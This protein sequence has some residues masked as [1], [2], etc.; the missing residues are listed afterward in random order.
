MEFHRLER[1]AW[2]DP[3]VARAYSEGFPTVTGHVAGPLLEAVQARPGG[4]LADIACGPGTVGRRAVDLG[5]RVV[6]V[7]L[8]RAMLLLPRHPPGPLI[9]VQ[10]SATALPLAAGRFDA[11]VSNFGLLHF[12]DPEAALA[13]AAR[14]LRPGGR[15]GWSVWGEDAEA[16]RVIPKA[17]ES[18]G[19]RPELPA[20]PG[21]FQFGAP[22]RFSVALAGAGL[23]DVTVRRLAWDARFNDADAFWRAFEQGSARTR[24]AI[25]ALSEA[26]RTAVRTEV[27]RRLSE[28]QGPAGLAVPTTALVAAGLRP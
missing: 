9:A 5:S 12:P 18:L 13:Q 6:A 19:L 25:R 26:D 11:A 15:A 14:L 21:F 24:A 23:T 8:S 28:F 3:S 20:G 27:R 1:T 7:D 2:Q 10:G 22:D 4:L 17:M 16:F